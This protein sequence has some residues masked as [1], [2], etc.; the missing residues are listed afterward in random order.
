[1]IDARASG[2]ASN[3]HGHDGVLN[4]LY[5]AAQADRLAH[6]Y[7]LVGPPHVGKMTLAVHLAQLVNCEAPTPGPCLTCNQCK[8]IASG[9]HADVQITGLP[10]TEEGALGTQ[11]R[12]EQVRELRK[13]ASLRP[14]EGRTRVFIIQDSEL[15]TN[16]AANSLLK[17]LEEPPPNVLLALLASDEDALLPTVLSRCQ[18]LA[19]RPMPFASLQDVLTDSYGAPEEQAALISRLSGGCPGWAISAVQDESVLD[20]RLTTLDEQINLAEADLA[21]RFRFA[22]SL[23]SAFYRDRPRVRGILALCQSWW[24]DLALCAAGAPDQIVN[25]HRIEQVEAQSQLVGVSAAHGF[26]KHVARARDLLDRNV[27]PRLALEWL[28]LKMPSAGMRAA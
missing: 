26:I 1:M 9:H 11:I 24:M 28:M 17:Y 16:E 27:T 7:V 23:G 13:Q 6:A 8:R 20:A 15:L 18:L 14:Y 2:T 4:L 21:T 10:T 5:T 3:I 12:I 22:A 25:I 19:L